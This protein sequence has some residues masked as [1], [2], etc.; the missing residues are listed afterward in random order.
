MC[1]AITGMPASSSMRI[2][3]MLLLC[4]LD[5]HMQPAALP[6]C[7]GIPQQIAC[8]GQKPTSPQHMTSSQL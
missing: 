4:I 7:C 6:V 8:L 3:A 2:H 1:T 5:Q